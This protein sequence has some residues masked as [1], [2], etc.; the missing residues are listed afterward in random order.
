MKSVLKKIAPFISLVFFGLAIWFLDQELGQYALGEIGGYIAAISPLHIIASLLLCG[1]SYLLL[2][3]YDLLG[4]QYIGEDLSFGKVAKAGFIGYAF[5]HNIGMALITGGSIRYRLYSSWGLNGLQVTKIVGFSAF[6]LWIG[7]CSTAGLSL[8]VYSPNL[9]DDLIP[10]VSLQVLGLILLAMVVLYMAASALTRS[11]LTVWRWE[12]TFPGFDMAL[13]QVVIASVDWLLASSVLYVLLPEAGIPFFGFVGVFLLAQIV[14]LFSQVPGGLGVFE[15]IMVLYLSEYM[16]GSNV[17]GILLVYRLIYYLL[18]LVAA[19]ALLGYQEYRANRRVVREFGAKTASWLPQVVPT[20]F[21]VMIFVAGVVL[22]FSGVMP[23][24]V[25]RMHWLQPLIPLPVIEMSH[26]FAS[27]VGAVLLVLAHGLQRRIDA[28]YHATVAVLV[29]GILFSLLKGVSYIE[30]I[31][32]AVML[33]ALVP[34]RREF[35][36]KAALFSESFSPVWITMMLMVVLS[37]IWLG[38]F[39]YRNVEYSREL[40]WQFTLL[41]DAPRYLRASVAILGLAIIFGL[42]KLLRPSTP[43]YD[44]SARE[45]LQAARALMRQ[46]PWA[47]S[48][49][50]LLGDKKLLFS[51]KE[52]A[53]IMYGVEDKSWIAM[54]DPLGAADEIRELA[55]QFKEL[56]ERND[57]WPVFYQVHETYLDLYRDLGLTILKLGEQARVKLGDFS[58]STQ[59]YHDITATHAAMEERGYT[60][61]LVSASRV[62]SR[63]DELHAVSDAW[64]SIPGNHE[65]RFSLGYFNEEYLQHFPVAA[66]RRDGQLVAFTNIWSG[67]R[68]FELGHDLIRFRPEAPEGITDYLLTKVMLWGR[69]EG[70]QWYNLGLA[71][72]SEMDETKLEPR[73]VEF[74]DQLYDYGE[75][76]YNFRGL[77][78]HKQKF[79][80]EWT[81]LY[82]AAPAGLKLPTVLS[83]LSELISGHN[84]PVPGSLDEKSA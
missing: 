25:P 10:Y 43:L 81:P 72:L 45:Q 33:L 57:G 64:L 69:E 29:F 83:N 6:T 63:M 54:G 51:E 44:G 62:A 21:S 52:E 75:H 31:I 23:S 9:P 67:A 27:L 49:L 77:R 58:L 22:L 46:T 84:K 34:A 36:R 1:L 3:G 61:E 14:G 68:R 28:A 2:T 7:F 37:S 70:Y 82:L 65:K 48:N 53:C 79:K 71:P 73:W 74:A 38:L 32:L 41:G 20:A 30:A 13:K 24:E 50:L 4:V 55:W 56:S 35:Y 5:S 42:V 40:W 39:S 78:H 17:V 26:F 8:L 19:M 12:L 66:I 11:D 16:S 76:L 18:P 59:R 60:F 80:P 15:S 47:Q